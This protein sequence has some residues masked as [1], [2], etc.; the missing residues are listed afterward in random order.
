MTT[1]CAM[2]VPSFSG[3]GGG[4]QDRARGRHFTAIYVSRFRPIQPVGGGGGGGGGA[5]HLRLI[6]SVWGGCPLSANSDNEV[7]ALSADSTSGRWM[8]SWGCACM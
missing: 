5:V 1:V 2:G 3:R 8:L 4:G 6:Q 7:S